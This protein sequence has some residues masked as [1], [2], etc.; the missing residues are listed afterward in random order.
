MPR[1]RRRAI[2]PPA[3]QRSTPASRPKITSRAAP[4]SWRSA[5]PRSAGARRIQARVSRPFMPHFQHGKVEIAF[6]DEGVGELIVLVHGFASTKEI[7]WVYPAW[8]STLVG[9]GRRAIAL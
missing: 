5:S 4:P 3:K 6:L 2:L 8:V 9:A 1:T 7:N